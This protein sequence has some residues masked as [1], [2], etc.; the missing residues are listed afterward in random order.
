MRKVRKKEVN[1]VL[2]KVVD[3]LATLLNSD[4]KNCAKYGRM[5]CMVGD[6]NSSVSPIFRPKTRNVW[7]IAS[8]VFIIQ[9][10]INKRIGEEQWK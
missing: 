4:K 9:K 6:R 10:R 5:T 2:D 7:I 3:N 1:W 8:L